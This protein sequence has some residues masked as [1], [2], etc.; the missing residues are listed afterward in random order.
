[1]PDPMRR[2]LPLIA[3]AGV[4]ICAASA[5]ASPR[6]G[7]YDVATRK[8]EAGFKIVSFKRVF[9]DDECY[10]SADEI[11]AE[12][13]KEM[14]IPVVVTPSLDAVQGFELVNVVS[15]ETACNRLVLAIRAGTKGRVFI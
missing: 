4:L 7:G 9:A 14:H 2:L 5:Q 1:M 3:L 8:L 11:A 15:G 12:L 6:Q 13:E 10:P